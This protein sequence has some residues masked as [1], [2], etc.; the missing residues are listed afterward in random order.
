MAVRHIFTQGY[1]TLHVGLFKQHY[2]IRPLLL[3]IVTVNNSCLNVRCQRPCLHPYCLAHS[4]GIALELH[5]CLVNEQWRTKWQQLSA[6][7]DLLLGRYFCFAHHVLD[8]GY[9]LL[10]KDVKVYS[11]CLKL[12]A[13]QH[14]IVRWVLN[15]GEPRGKPYIDKIRNWMILFCWDSK[16]GIRGSNF[17]FFFFCTCSWGI[18]TVTVVKVIQPEGAVW[19]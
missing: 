5:K 3:C 13:L 4:L 19:A 7:M 11:F 9:V 14:L 10:N 1:H 12:T 17:S 16:E 6:K 8:W 15:R 18:N 2:Q